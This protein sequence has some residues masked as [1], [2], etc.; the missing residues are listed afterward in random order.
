MPDSVPAVDAESPVTPTPPLQAEEPKAADTTTREQ[1]GFLQILVTVALSYLLL[2]SHGRVLTSEILEF[3]ILGLLV[4]LLFLLLLPTRL[5]GARWFVWVLVLGNT[6]LSSAIFY[7][8]GN[9]DPGLYCSLFLIV[10]IAASAPSLKQH[11]IRS[12]AIIV[13]Y[14]I[15]LI[16]W[17]V[18]DNSLAEDHLLR[19]PVLLVMTIFFGTMLEKKAPPPPPLDPW[20]YLTIRESP[21]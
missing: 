2:F 19:A 10:M 3:V 8:S 21:K 5:W 18:Q 14:Q 20:A 12:V 13:A 1:F 4:V 11:Y 16:A 6:A 15:V 7:F 17:T 9:G